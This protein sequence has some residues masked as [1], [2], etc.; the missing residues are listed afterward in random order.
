M[1]FRNE[2]VGVS[3]RS[4]GLMAVA[5]CAMVS[6]A[7]AAQAVNVPI[8]GL[9]NTG[10]DAGKAALAKNGATDSHWTITPQ[11]TGVTSQATTYNVDPNGC[12]YYCVPDAAWVGVGSGGFQSY[13]YSLS[14]DMSG[15]NLSS[16]SLW[17]Q[18]GADNEASVYLNGHLL[19]SFLADHDGS[20]HSYQAF[21]GLHDFSANGAD[22]VAGMNVLSFFVTDYD[23]PSALLVTG[24]GSSAGF[25]DRSALSGAVPE[26]S[27]WSMMILGFGFAGAMMRR[28]RNTL[29]TA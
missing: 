28:R 5:L 23:A 15:R 27:T 16:A 2:F 6:A 8:V 14:F 26:A 9:Y 10:V 24:L 17:G 1:L 3:M 4:L 11:A 12:T 20:Y 21:Q 7:P 19:A 29:A 25:A 18:F 22:F 13:T